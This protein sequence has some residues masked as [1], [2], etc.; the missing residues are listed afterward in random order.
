MALTRKAG[1]ARTTR[2][3]P[4]N[5]SRKA[6]NFARAYHSDERVQ[7]VA[8]LRCACGCGVTPCENAHT[9]SGGTGRKAD[10]DTIIPLAK[11]CHAVQH[12][13]GWGAIGL[14]QG[15]AR[16]IARQVERMWGR[17]NAG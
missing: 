10:Y 1:I 11:K 9:E 7:W 15:E 17:R 5:P 2:I 16:D 6:A 13:K 14:N 8:S 4:R 3:K 12:A